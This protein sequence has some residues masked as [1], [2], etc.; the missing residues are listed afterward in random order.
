MSVWHFITSQ[1][2]DVTGQYVLIRSVD[3]CHDIWV[4][5]KYQSGISSILIG[6][7]YLLV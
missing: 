1:T 4:K 6:I 5:Y 7:K 2:R 3:P